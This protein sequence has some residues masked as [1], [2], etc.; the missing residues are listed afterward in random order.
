ML[1][2]VLVLDRF[3]I[4]QYFPLLFGALAILISANFPFLELLGN[5]QI[6]S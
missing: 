2:T 6:I 4:F 3:L 1:L 5:F